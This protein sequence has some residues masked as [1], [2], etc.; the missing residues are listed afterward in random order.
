MARFTIIIRKANVEGWFVPTI[1]DSFVGQKMS[2]SWVK[3]CYGVNSTEYRE[4]HEFY[5]INKKNRFG[6][7]WVTKEPNKSNYDISV[8]GRGESIPFMSS[9]SD[10]IVYKNS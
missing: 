7:I 8:T 3:K 9:N 10:Y 5:Y 2:R 6:V 4:N 1:R